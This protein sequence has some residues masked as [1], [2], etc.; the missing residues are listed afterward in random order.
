MG[1]TFNFTFIISN[2]FFI[3]FFF[4]LLI[5]TYINTLIST[6]IE[7]LHARQLHTIVYA[8]EL[9]HSTPTQRVQLAC[10]H[11]YAH[12][13]NAFTLLYP[14]I[15]SVE[16]SVCWISTDS[17][18]TKMMRRKFITNINYSFVFKR[19]R[20]ILVTF[21]AIPANAIPPF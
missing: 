15:H 5:R 19:N 11:S 2:N 12:K 9:L 14:C 7:S 6:T 8:N 17:N 16:K 10:A 18:Q 1:R 4:L 21:L 13:V 20:I 3:H